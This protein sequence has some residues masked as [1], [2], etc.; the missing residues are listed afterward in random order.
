MC[1]GLSDGLHGTLWWNLT[2]CVS[3]FLRACFRIV[4]VSEELHHACSFISE[5]VGVRGDSVKSEELGIRNRVFA[6]LKVGRGVE[7]ICMG[8]CRFVVKCFNC[9]S[10]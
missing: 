8:S 2:F 10:G 3:A 9:G 7:E 4:S 1:L 6:S 5:I